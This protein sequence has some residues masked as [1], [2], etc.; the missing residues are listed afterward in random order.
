MDTLISQCGHYRYFLKRP[1]ETA[2]IIK[3]PVVFVL[4]NPSTAD[5]KEDDAT[6][7]R[8]KGFARFWGFDGTIVLNLYAYRATKPK[9][10]W[11][12]DDPVGKDNNHWL[13]HFMGEH[14]NVVCAWGAQAKPVRIRE[15]LSIVEN[16]TDKPNLWCLGT[17]K[18]GNPKHPL[19]IK[20]NQRLIKW[21]P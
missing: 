15:F 8:C 20:A 2:S 17:T 7:R 1:T 5:A 3:E 21:H 18:N 10:L 13:T 6:I 19:Y 4:L 11:Y 16:Y 9:T 14:T 12:I